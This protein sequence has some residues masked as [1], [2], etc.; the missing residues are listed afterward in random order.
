MVFLALVVVPITRR[1]EPRRLAV[2]LIA[3]SGR[4]FRW[5]GWVCL[6]VLILTGILNLTYRGFGWGDVWSGNIFAGAFGRTLGVKLFLVATLLM[7]SIVHDFWLGPRATA[8]GQAAPDTLEA[9]RLRRW[10]SWLGRLNLLLA[11]AV[12]ALAVVLVRG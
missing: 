8:V 12:I 11:L 7:I 4:R 9:L 2:S 5:V 3:Q 6:A 1:L 10:A